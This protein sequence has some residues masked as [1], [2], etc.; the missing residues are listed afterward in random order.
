MGVSKRVYSHDVFSSML[1]LTVLE[2]KKEYSAKLICVPRGRSFKVFME[3]KTPMFIFFRFL[4]RKDFITE[5]EFL[6][7]LRR[8]PL[9]K[10]FME[11]KTSRFLSSNF[12][13]KIF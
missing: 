5:E 7:R 1:G 13:A 6:V 12:I 2:R 8:V 11:C 4:L 3:Y 9:F 10:V